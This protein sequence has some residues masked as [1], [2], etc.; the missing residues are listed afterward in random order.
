[1]ATDKAPTE[2]AN[3]VRTVLSSLFPNGTVLEIPSSVSTEVVALTA[4]DATDARPAS[5]LQARLAQELNR[6]GWAVADR[7]QND[8]ATALYAGKLN[9]GGGTFGVEAPTISFAGV[10]DRG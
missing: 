2:L 6:A 7:P 5:E 8:E 4:F 1:M 9:V 10:V 3:E